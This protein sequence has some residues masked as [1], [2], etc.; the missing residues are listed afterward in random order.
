MCIFEQYFAL[1]DGKF[2]YSN[3]ILV[4]IEEFQMNPLLNSWG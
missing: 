4:K 3:K 1:K 2:F